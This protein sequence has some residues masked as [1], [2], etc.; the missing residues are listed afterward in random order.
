M[1]TVFNVGPNFNLTTFSEQLAGLYRTKGFMVNVA[2][3]NGNSVITFE[4]DV[5]G[6]NYLLGLGEGIKATVSQ[7][8]N[9]VMINYS[10]G[11][12]TGKIVGFAVGWI[13]CFI[14]LITA[15]IGT[16]KQ[17]SLNDKITG[18]AMIIASNLG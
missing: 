3:F 8:G 14:P 6:I 9:A 18:D 16:V 13:L 2:Y 11:D 5:G 15:L 1:M 4:K 17:L 10:D 12:W 7:N